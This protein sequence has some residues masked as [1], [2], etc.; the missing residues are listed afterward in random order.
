MKCTKSMKFSASPKFWTL[1]ESLT[2]WLTLKN[3]LEDIHIFEFHRKSSKP[4]HFYARNGEKNEKIHFKGS[5]G[6]SQYV[7][8]QRMF[9]LKRVFDAKKRIRFISNDTYSTHSK[10]SRAHALLL[11]LCRTSHK[12]PSWQQTNSFSATAADTVF[13]KVHGKKAPILF[14][15]VPMLFETLPSNRMLFIIHGFTVLQR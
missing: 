7:C 13:N 6:D 1:F 9:R 2:P 15:K 10:Y 12:I 5:S 8:F 3:W 11:V 14:S 4:R